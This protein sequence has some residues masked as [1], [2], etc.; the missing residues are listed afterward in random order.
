MSALLL[1]PC[2]SVCG[3][4]AWDHCRYEAGEKAKFKEGCKKAEARRQ[5]PLPEGC[6]ELLA[7]GSWQNATSPEEMARIAEP[8][9]EEGLF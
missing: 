6:D 1:F 9:E 5:D 8:P 2:P 7:V 3:C 4:P